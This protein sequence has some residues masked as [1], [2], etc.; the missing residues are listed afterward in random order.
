MRC[1]KN[2]TVAFALVTVF[3]LAGACDQAPAKN[4]SD[5]DDLDTLNDEEIALP[6]GQEEDGEE[7]RPPGA[8]ALC[9]PNLLVCSSCS[10]TT[11][12]S[13]NGSGETC[14]SGCCSVG[15]GG[16]YCDED[17]DPPDCKTCDVDVCFVG[18]C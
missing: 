12:C 15:E 18:D 16:R 7:T 3:G 10:S 5:L 14:G 11:C 1:T 4:K 13:A 6:G 9:V 2:L 8:D 17:T